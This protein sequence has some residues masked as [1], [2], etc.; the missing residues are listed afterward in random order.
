MFAGVTEEGGVDAMLCCVEAY[1]SRLPAGV[2]LMKKL[3]TRCP[4]P[5]KVGIKPTVHNALTTGC[6]SKGILA[7]TSG[8][9]F[10][11]SACDTLKRKIVIPIP[12]KNETVPLTR[13]CSRLCSGVFCLRRCRQMG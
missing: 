6:S 7:R 1:A 12:V 10:N 5:A 3:P 9:S 4:R 13:C 11:T 2:D 8:G